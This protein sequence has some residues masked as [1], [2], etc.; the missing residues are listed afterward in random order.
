MMYL[1][2]TTD[3]DIVAPNRKV[4][5]LL[6]LDASAQEFNVVYGAYPEND[7]EIAIQTRSILQV[8]ILPGSTRF[9]FL[10]QLNSHEGNDNTMH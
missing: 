6:G 8:M 2:P 10:I 9:P 5:E 4:R 7:K 1:Y 3:N